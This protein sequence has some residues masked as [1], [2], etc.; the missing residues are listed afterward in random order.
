MCVV[1]RKKSGW[2]LRL[3]CQVRETVIGPRELA[4]YR[5]KLSVNVRIRS[6]P[7]GMTS[8]QAFSR[9]WYD[10]RHGSR[11]DPSAVF[12]RPCTRVTFKCRR[13]RQPKWLSSIFVYRDTPGK[14]GT[15]QPNKPSFSLKG[16]AAC[17][18]KP[19]TAS[20]RLSGS[21]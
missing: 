14:F 9:M 12:A 4:L 15:F 5:K 11:V 21:P 6:E 10:P 16:Q 2:N 13:E 8:D 20:V 1:T 7:K 18:A 3:E 19:V 17:C